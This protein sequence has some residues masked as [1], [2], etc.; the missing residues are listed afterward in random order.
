[1]YLNYRFLRG[2]PINDLE[3]NC[4][5]I[6]FRVVLYVHITKSLFLFFNM[7]ETEYHA[8]VDSLLADRKFYKV[9]DK[10]P[11]SSTEEDECCSVGVK[12]EWY[13]P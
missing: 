1:M 6:T 3:R 11:T 12:E 13:H 5:V 10:E 9:L 4:Q 7:D 8:K 2:A